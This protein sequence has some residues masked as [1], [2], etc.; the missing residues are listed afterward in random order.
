MKGG[1][2]SI[3]IAALLFGCSGGP[4][5]P[6]VRT[7][8]NDGEGS[9]IEG[10]R[11]VS[12]ADKTNTYIVGSYL[13]TWKSAS[14]EGSVAGLKGAAGGDESLNQLAESLL[15]ASEIFCKAYPASKKSVYSIVTKLLPI[16]GYKITY[17]DETIGAVET[18]YVFQEKP[19]LAHGISR[20]KDRYV[21]SLNSPDPDH[22]VVRIFRDVYISRCFKSKGGC[23]EYLRATSVGHNEAWMLNHISEQL[24]GSP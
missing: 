4:G 2:T 9:L 10:C 17:S 6:F 1:S 23:S 20:W 13:T 3:L 18:G 12:Q 24:S 15:P 22:T 19:A 11:N 16:L 14:R 7:S 21:V 5:A 8:T